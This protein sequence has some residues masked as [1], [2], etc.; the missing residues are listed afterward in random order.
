M[1]ISVVIPSYNQS[2]TVRD[3]LRSI[4]MQDR[5]A[6]EIIVVDSS[7]DQTPRIVREEFPEVQLI[8]RE[9]QTFCGVARNIGVEAASGDAVVFTDTDCV[10]TPE[11][12][13]AIER[14]YEE[15]GCHAVVGTVEGP[16]LENWVAKLDRLQFSE[17]LPASPAR[18]TWIGPG[19]NFSVLREVYLDL[20]GCPDLERSQDVAF[21][22]AMVKQYGPMR[23]VPQAVVQHVSSHDLNKLLARQ[24]KG[25]A[26]FAYSRLHDG[27]LSGA[28]AVR[29]PFLIP[30]LPLVKSVRILTRFWR[31]DKGQFANIMCH[32]PTFARCMFLWAHGCYDAVYA[33]RRKGN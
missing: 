16:Q 1:K 9:E 32:I 2:D 28:I 19:C 27:S 5:S 24:R 10:A 25:G 26:G 11:W 13:E 22:A 33:S 4:L 31:Y 30:L 23:L 7:T 21:F 8:R 15:F 3:C 20:G 6:D 29:Y 14:A 18:W 17:Y 12:L